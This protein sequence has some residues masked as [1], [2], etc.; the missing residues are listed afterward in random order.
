MDLIEQGKEL[1]QEGNYAEALKVFQKALENDAK[2]ADLLFFIGTCHSS[3]GE[4]PIA[5]YY[6]QEVLKIDP[7]HGRTKMVWGGLKEVEAQSPSGAKASPAPSGEPTPLDT[8]DSLT[9]DTTREPSD[10]WGEAFPDA[11]LKPRRKRG[12]GILLW[13]LVALA[14]AAL[15]Y[16]KLAPRFLQ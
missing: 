1:A 12:L 7:D 6:Y 16:F 8:P 4:F 14:V 13:I 11:M 9:A 3:L 5:K 2:N 10:P 15:V